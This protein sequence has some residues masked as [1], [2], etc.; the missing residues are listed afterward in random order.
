MFLPWFTKWSYAVINCWGS[1]KIV[2]ETKIAEYTLTTEGST[3]DISGYEL[4]ERFIQLIELLGGKA[5][6]SF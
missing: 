1:V 6:D 5:R 4:G 2:A 3:F